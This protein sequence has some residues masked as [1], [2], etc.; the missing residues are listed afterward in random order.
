MHCPRHVSIFP[1][2]FSAMQRSID[3]CDFLHLMKPP[4]NNARL[5][6]HLHHSTHLYTTWTRG[7][8]RG[9]K[10]HTHPKAWDIP[11]L[12]RL[13]RLGGGGKLFGTRSSQVLVPYYLLWGVM[14]KTAPV[15][16][17]LPRHHNG[18]LTPRHPAGPLPPRLQCR[19]LA[20]PRGPCGVLGGG[21][22]RRG[23]RPLGAGC[24]AYP[25]L[26]YHK[27]GPVSP[28]MLGSNNLKRIFSHRVYALSQP[29]SA[30]KAISPP[31]PR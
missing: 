30:L 9:Q 3:V 31:L 2:S 18:S 7:V 22:Q 28:T 23:E 19:H 12:W 6:A 16:Q 20:Q 13:C 17:V 8:C 26:F 27:N 14:A 1:I 11:L 21:A 5:S 29:Q 15:S 25:P 4:T 24:S 10:T